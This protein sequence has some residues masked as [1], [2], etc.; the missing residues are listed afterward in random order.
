MARILIE[1]SLKM[2][3]ILL[4]TILCSFYLMAAIPSIPVPSNSILKFQGA[5]TGGQAGIGFSLL[6]L[7]KV[8]FQNLNSERWIV[9]VGNIKGKEN[10]GLPGY[11]HVQLQKNPPQLI[12]NFNQMPVSLVD[13]LHLTK[14]VKDSFYVRNGRILSDPTDKTL[15]LILDLKKPLQLKV[16]QIKGQKKTSKLVFDMFL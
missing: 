4:G 13:E 10:K 9:D 16:L 12:I 8:F 7:E 14:F 1:W 11:Y 3:K 6:K 2:L 15:T 5:L